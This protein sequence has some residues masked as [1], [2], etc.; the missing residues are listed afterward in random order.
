MKT[1]TKMMLMNSNRRDYGR[2]EHDDMRYSYGYD[3]YNRHDYDMRNE[4]SGSRGY[5]REGGSYPI[6]PRSHY[7]EELEGRFRDRRGRE[8]SEDGRFVSPR[9]SYPI[10]PFI[11]PI[12]ERG[13]RG[14]RDGGGE[15][16]QIGFVHPYEMESNYGSRVE[17]PSMEEVRHRT[18]ERVHG[19]ASGGMNAP[20]TR[21]M[22]MGWAD[23][24]ENAD[25][26]HGPHWAM[27]Q[28]KELQ[29][30]KGIGHDPVE[31][32]VTMN[33]MYS[34]YCKI[35]KRYN[36]NTPDFY[37]SMAKAFL[38]DKDA[39]PDKLAK[40]YEHVVQH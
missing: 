5:D 31:F 12:Y 26:T 21:G 8:H 38:D 18:S 11:P 15:M 25:G 33:M 30:K 14:G 29:D 23:Q 13:E 39:V 36:V 20:F 4:R 2:N 24:M 27:E 19:Y 34:D 16:N 9:N 7:P 40:Y 37:A 32:F 6:Y 35:A 3:T 17:N 1:R 10:Y 28:T 22:A